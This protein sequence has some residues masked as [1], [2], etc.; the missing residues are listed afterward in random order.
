MKAANLAINYQAKLLKTSVKPDHIDGFNTA[1]FK[2]LLK[3]KDEHTTNLSTMFYISGVSIF[4]NVLLVIILCCRS[5]FT[6]QRETL[7]FTT[8]E[9]Q[10]DI[11]SAVIKNS[12]HN[13][14]EI[15]RVVNVYTQTTFE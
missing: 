12:D 5:C 6:K 15:L 8:L 3:K 11:T 9:T 2:L 14:R 4:S 7:R 13:L 10:T 1:K